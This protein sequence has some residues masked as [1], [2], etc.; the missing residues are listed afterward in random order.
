MISNDEIAKL[1]FVDAL[2]AENNASLESNVVIVT[3]V[4]T[5]VDLYTCGDGTQQVNCYNHMISLPPTTT[6]NDETKTD[7]ETSVIL[8]LN[9]T[10]FIGVG[11][12]VFT[13][14]CGLMIGIYKY[15]KNRRCEN[16]S[17]T[18]RVRNSIV[19]NNNVDNTIGN[20]QISSNTKASIPLQRVQSISFANTEA[21]GQDLRD[22]I[23]V[24]S[25]TC[26]MAAVNENESS[27]DD[28]DSS[29]GSVYEC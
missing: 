13:V 18:K 15:K 2:K 9:I 26:D 7:D 21:D 5:N 16:N 4:T 3:G 19:T 1:A 23:N 10:T 25:I 28:S 8:G 27:D 12:S 29:D 20:S 17:T 6:V 22:T 14:L 11:G 24:R